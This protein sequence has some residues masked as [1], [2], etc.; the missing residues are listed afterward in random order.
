MDER[1]LL[2]H[3]FQQ[4]LD[5][6]SLFVHSGIMTRSMV[7]ERSTVIGMCALSVSVQ[8]YVLWIGVIV[9]YVLGVPF[10]KWLLWWNHGVFF[11]IEC[12]G[13]VL[14]CFGWRSVFAWIAFAFFAATWILDSILSV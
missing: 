10:P 6:A 4:K 9:F 5:V 14:A 7:L 11:V 3:A 13:F 8:G 2:Q 1:L 12:V